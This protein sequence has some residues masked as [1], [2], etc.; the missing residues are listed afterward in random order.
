MHS[1][2]STK[3][4]GYYEYKPMY[5]SKLP[6]RVIDFSDAADKARHDRMVKLVEAMLALHKQLAGVKSESE[7]GAV[8]RQIEATDAEIDRL[9]YA[10]YGLTEEEIAIVEGR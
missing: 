10:L 2:S 3:Q 7:R 4:G 5:L 9:V 8:Q 6:I 1:I